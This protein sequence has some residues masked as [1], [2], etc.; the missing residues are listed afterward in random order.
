MNRKLIHGILIV[1]LTGCIDP[2]FPSELT[3]TESILIVD[4]FIDT[5]GSSKLTLARSQSI[6]DLSAPFFEV[7]AEVWIEDE[8]GNKITLLDTQDGNYIL[9]NANLNASKYRLRIITTNQQEYASEYVSV[10]DSPQID[11]VTWRIA[12][13]ENIEILVS[14]HGEPTSSTYYQWIFEEVWE[15]RSF[16]NSMYIFDSNTRSV[17]YNGNQNI[18][19]CWRSGQSSKINIESTNR[20]ADNRVSNFQLTSFSWNDERTRLKYSILIKQYSLSKDAFNYWQQLKKNNEDIG[21]IFGSL[22]SEL[23]GNLINL[24]D[25]SKPVVGFFSVGTVA[26]K[27]IFIKNSDFPPPVAWETPYKG[28]DFDT[29]FLANIPDFSGPPY[30]LGGEIYV[31]ASLVG[32]AYSTDDCVDCRKSGGTNLKPDYWQ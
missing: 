19:T 22:P 3:S 5:S 23:K 10:L 12:Q 9:E 31:G 27:R 28:C 32:Y 24:E 21:T 1:I 15:Y 29:L 18:Y 2:Y 20:F 11:S 14:S 17:Y 26:Q 6:T 7:G 16:L 30:L 13:D 8:I 25:E 4:G